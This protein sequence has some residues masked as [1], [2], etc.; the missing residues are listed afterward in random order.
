MVE[1]IDNYIQL[2]IL[3]LCSGVSFYKAVTKRRRS[4]VLVSLFY[5]AFFL[6]SLYWELFYYFRGDSPK[7]FYVSEFDWY[8]SYLFLFLF[9]KYQSNFKTTAAKCRIQWLI[10]VLAGGLSIYY[11]TFGQISSNIISAILMSMLGMAA[12]KGLFFGNA[13][14]KPV[15]IATLVFFFLEYAMWTTSCLI[16]EV[17]FANPY[18]YIDMAVSLCLFVM[19]LCFVK[20]LKDEVDE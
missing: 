16:D 10:P 5:S 2:A 19:L 18:Y 8:V 20:V 14:M 6:G 17:S 3:G 12:V 15:Y 7:K 9:L 13:K 11:M 1:S 4:W